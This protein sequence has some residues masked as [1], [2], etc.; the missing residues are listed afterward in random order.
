MVGQWAGTQPVAVMCLISYQNDPGEMSSPLK[1]VVFLCE[2]DLA[3]VFQDCHEIWLC[4]ESQELG[5]VITS[6]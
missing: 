1:E 3:L 2:I 4:M 6:G 5:T